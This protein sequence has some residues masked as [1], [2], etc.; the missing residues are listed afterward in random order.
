MINTRRAWLFPQKQA[1][2]T[3]YGLI[4]WRQL[5]ARDNGAK[6]QY[7]RFFEKTDQ[8]YFFIVGQLGWSVEN[9][10]SETAIFYSIC[11]YRLQTNYREY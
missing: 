3:L 9:I 1:R 8:I 5:L 10:F 11:G 2:E 4:L 6:I 7:F